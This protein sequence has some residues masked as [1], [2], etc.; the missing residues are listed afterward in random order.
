MP[1]VHLDSLF[2]LSRHTGEAERGKASVEV[3]AYFRSEIFGI[4]GAA[5]PLPTLPR[6]TGEEN[7]EV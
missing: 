3:S 7:E 6:M 2:H 4:T 5:L 1:L